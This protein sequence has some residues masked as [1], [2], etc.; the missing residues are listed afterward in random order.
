MSHLRSLLGGG[1]AW[2]QVPS[3]GSMSRGGVG[4]C[5]GGYTRQGWVCK[6]G[7]Y[8]RGG[9]YTRDTRV[10]GIP[11]GTGTLGDRYMRGVGGYTRGGVSIQE[12]VSI[13]EGVGSGTPEGV[14]G[15]QAGGMH[16]TGML[17][18]ETCKLNGF[19]KT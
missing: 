19:F 6:R 1:Y 9:R 13:P 11:E 15:W 17:S 7:R 5:R 4:L 14:S 18:C 10:G 8:A 3:G 16:P 12:G 2:S